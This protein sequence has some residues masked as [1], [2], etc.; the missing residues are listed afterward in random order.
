VGPVTLPGYLDR[1]QFVTRT[2]DNELR[3]A[4]F[5]RWAERMDDSVAR[6]VSVELGALLGSD[7]VVPVTSPS[8]GRT[9]YTV[10]LNISRFECGAGEECVLETRFTLRPAGAG[11]APVI[12]AVTARVIAADATYEARAVAMSQ[13]LA[14]LS[15]EIADAIRSQTP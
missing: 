1:P 7:E 8:A 11:A 12:H 2:G 13:T 15:R 14:D 4:E 6:V 9:D 5:D 3:L 10:E